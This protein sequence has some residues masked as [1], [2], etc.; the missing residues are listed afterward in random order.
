MSEVLDRLMK[1][2]CK[3]PDGCWLWQ[4]TTRHGYGVIY[5]KE[6]RRYERT[7][8]LS[9]ELHRGP[10]PEGEGFHGICV[11]HYC[12]VRNCI[13]P[14]HLFL[15]TQLD[16]VRDRDRKKRHGNLKKT[17]CPY[18]HLY[19]ES[20]TYFDGHRWRTCKTCKTRN[21]RSWMARQKLARA[22]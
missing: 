21:K 20:N 9:W 12:D 3:L 6:T 5:V 18:G 13:N 19:D 17:H 15:G 8:R 4:G 16:N 11:C 22:S 14:D 7:H 2:V 1:K 10:I